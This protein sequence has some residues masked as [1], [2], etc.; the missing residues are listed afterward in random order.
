MPY[1]TETLSKEY[2]GS[3]ES[4]IVSKWP[5]PC[6][7]EDNNIAKNEINF[8][9]SLLTEIRVIRSELNI[10]Y[11]QK[12]ELLIRNNQSLKLSIITKYEDIICDISKLSSIKIIGNE[13]PNGSATGVVGELSIGIPLSGT[14][15]LDDEIIRLKKEINKVDEE[16]LKFDQNLSNKNFI[17]RAPEKV[18]NELKDKRNASIDKKNKLNEALNRVDFK[19]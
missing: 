19:K 9:I 1:V 10:P 17:N 12:L 3:K 2:F 14:I 16:I 4:L 15:N 18:V 7:I 13:F 8:L 11:K 5:E 6:L